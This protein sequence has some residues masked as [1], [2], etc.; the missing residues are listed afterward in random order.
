M[1]T[2]H[3]KALAVGINHQVSD[4]LSAME[5]VDR[6]LKALHVHAGQQSDLDIVQLAVLDNATAAAISA[7]YL[8][9][10]RSF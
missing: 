3:C 1:R 8:V 9:A 4:L 2:G 10:V 7:R 6:Q 5:G